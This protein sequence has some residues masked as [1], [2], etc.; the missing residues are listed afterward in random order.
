MSNELVTRVKNYK[1]ALKYIDGLTGFT[2]ENFDTVN[3][4]AGDVFSPSE[5]RDQW[6]QGDRMLDGA[7]ELKRMFR[8]TLIEGID[9]FEKVVG[10]VSEGD[11]SGLGA[12]LKKLRFK[13]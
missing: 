4:L 12:L 13:R 10:P 2:F 6:N 3:H 11:S 5:L 7:G 1:K 9:T 8:N